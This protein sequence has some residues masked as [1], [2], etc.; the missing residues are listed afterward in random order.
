MF[1]SELFYPLDEVDR[2]SFLRG[3]GA[4]AI[5]GTVGG[6]AEKLSRYSPEPRWV[7]TPAP[8]ISAPKNLGPVEIPKLSPKQIEQV[9]KEAAME[10]GL[11]GNELAQFMAQCS[12]ESGGFTEME[13]NLNYS[14]RILRRTFPRIFRSDSMAA[15]YAGKPEMIANL[16]YANKN[17]NGDVA[18]GD[19]WRYRGRGFI[20]LTGR[21]NYAKATKEMHG[22][23]FVDEPDLAAEPGTA[24]DIALWY[25]MHRVRPNVR[26]F[27]NTRRTTQ[28]INPGMV[29]V[30]D[31]ERRYTQYRNN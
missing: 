9:V 25:W 15:E 20:H 26:D 16:V 2:R 3:L 27:A 17:G 12:H 1:L 23:N 5:A 14:A 19:G 30:K 31:R 21:Y 28:Q 29:G 4:A 6:A 11:K 18:S 13:E 22:L 24:T 8:A 10:A 7:T